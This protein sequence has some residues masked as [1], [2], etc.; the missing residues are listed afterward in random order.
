MLTHS[1]KNN[2]LDAKNEFINKHYISSLN[3]ATMMDRMV[4]AGGV[5]ASILLKEKPRDTDIFILNARKEDR[6]AVLNYININHW[7]INKKTKKG[8]AA[9]SGYPVNE[10]IA[11]VW[12]CTGLN[13]S[14]YDIIFTDYNTPEEVILGFDYMH[15]KVWYH[16]GKLNLTEQTYKAIMNMKLVLAPDRTHDPLRKQ[17]FIDRGWKE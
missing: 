10:R 12:K 9:T 13:K 16:A 2:C 14:E 8:D 4:F 3:L 7:T 11:E 1:E 17:K 15:S 6:E 5:F